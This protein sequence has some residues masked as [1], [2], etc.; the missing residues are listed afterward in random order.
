MNKIKTFTATEWYTDTNNERMFEFSGEP[1][2]NGKI[3]HSYYD[4][5]NETNWEEWMD[6]INAH[7]NELNQNGYRIINFYMDKGN[8]INSGPCKIEQKWIKYREY[9]I[10]IVL[11]SK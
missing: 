3:D 7:L 10:T 8:I 6:F 2:D 5:Y 11:E 9:R 4:D 1:W